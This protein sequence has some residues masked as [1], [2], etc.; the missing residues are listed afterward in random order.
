MKTISRQ[1]IWIAYNVR[2]ILSVSEI[3]AELREPGQSGRSGNGRNR[4]PVPSTECDRRAS[5]YDPAVH[6]WNYRSNRQEAYGLPCSRRPF[7][8][9][10][11]RSGPCVRR[12]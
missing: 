4:D 7:H 5:P 3:V 11:N 9:K 6:Q 1:C 10:M 2:V 8:E 12:M